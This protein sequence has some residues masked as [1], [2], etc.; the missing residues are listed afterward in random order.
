MM[1]QNLCLGIQCVPFVGAD[2]GQVWA[3]N[4]TTSRTNHRSTR[5][6]D[7][8]FVPGGPM[9]PNESKFLAGPKHEGGS[10]RME[11]GGMHAQA[12]SRS[13]RRVHQRPR[14]GDGETQRDRRRLRRFQKR[15]EV[16]ER[17]VSGTSFSDA[18]APR[19]A[20]GSRNCARTHPGQLQS[21]GRVW[22]AI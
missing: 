12:L 5:A 16:E 13:E 21:H 6:C 9:C 11:P 7:G 17:V 4:I 1:L 15:T 20:S 3:Q 22:T 14:C 8:R 19:S 18:M 10:D 2:A